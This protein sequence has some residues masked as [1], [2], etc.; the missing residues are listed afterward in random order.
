MDNGLPYPFGNAAGAAPAAGQQAG[1]PR[2]HAYTTA[3]AQ[4]QFQTGTAPAGKTA[5]VRMA[6][7]TPPPPPVETST[8][9]AV[10]AP[11]GGFYVSLKSAPDEKAIQKDL[12]ALTEKYKGR[13]RRGA[14]LPPRS[15]IS[16]KGR[17]IPR[18]R[19]SAWKQARGHGPMHEDQ[20]RRRRQG[21]LRHQL[22]R[23]ALLSATHRLSRK[24][25]PRFPGFLLPG[26]W[27]VHSRDRV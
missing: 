21:M 16:V 3:P 27:T 9:A 14:D 23:A 18:R 20:G 25:R 11:A 2:R 12:T 1:A 13:A 19:R 8:A 4:P 26:E 22:S 7:H 24:R 15:R 17:H 6:A 10:P 5:P